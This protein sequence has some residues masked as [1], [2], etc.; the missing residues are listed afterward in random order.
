MGWLGSEHLLAGKNITYELAHKTR[1]LM[2]LLNNRIQIIHVATDVFFLLICQKILAVN[3]Y[4]G[5][6]S[7][8][9]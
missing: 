1:K 4:D 6:G 2:N 9:S 5:A 3:T 8:K 7:S